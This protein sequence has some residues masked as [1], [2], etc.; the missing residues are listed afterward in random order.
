M[1][2]RRLLL[3]AALAATLTVSLAA[4]HASAA[5]QSELAVA[6]A[7]AVDS[8]ARRM[9]GDARHGE[10]AR[11]VQDVQ[12]AVN[13]LV[14]LRDA[15]LPQVG[16]G[17]EDKEK[18]HFKNTPSAALSVKAERDAALALAT[19]LSHQ[20]SLLLQHRTTDRS[21]RVVMTDIALRNWTRDVRQAQTTAN[22]LHRAVR[23][24]RVALRGNENR[25]SARVKA[26]LDGGSARF[27]DLNNNLE[28]VERKLLARNKEDNEY[29]RELYNL[30]KEQE[31][32]RSSKPEDLPAQLRAIKA[33]V[34]TVTAEHTAVLAEIE[35][36]MKRH[37]ELRSLPSDWASELVRLQE[38]RDFWRAS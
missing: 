28:G 12:S 13:A 32:L 20:L 6:R 9:L 29:V 19:T 27:R 4:N 35:A 24:L 38:L 30:D 11:R 37:D 7:R 15:P 34:D 14:S 8:V 2:R 10:A 16:V 26:Q 25:A 1:T 22:R 36:L 18:L 3:A 17:A 33:E 23:T 5:S 31:A 21:A